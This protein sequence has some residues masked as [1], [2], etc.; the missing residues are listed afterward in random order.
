MGNIPGLCLISVLCLYLCLSPAAT[1][2]GDPNA[3][4]IYTTQSPCCTL[5]IQRPNLPDK[6]IQ[7]QVD[8]WLDGLA[9]EFHKKAIPPWESPKS[10]LSV[11]V[12]EIQRLAQFISLKF[13]IC[14]YMG[15]A[16]P[17]THIQTLVFDRATA[18]P[19]ELAD[20][21]TAPQ[22]ALDIISRTSIAQ[23]EDI[24]Q[25]PLT[26]MEKGRLRPRKENFK[27]FTL[28]RDRVHLFFPVYQTGPRGLG[29]QA[30]FVPHN[31]LYD[32]MKPHIRSALK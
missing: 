1:A 27:Y 26:P 2:G 22:T 5:S 6:R 7:D 9:Q 21:F 19:L 16:H 30:A 12:D 4:P 32:A 13:T 8:H 29:P 17:N 28:A 24:R 3:I 11:H 23:L 15:G 31:A 25:R 14:E 18:I 20:L 10:E